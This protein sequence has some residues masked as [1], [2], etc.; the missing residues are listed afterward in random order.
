MSTVENSPKPVISAVHGM[1]L[2]G[3]MELALASHWRL[4]T[5]DTV[6]GLP[7]VHLGILPGAGGTQVF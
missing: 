1:A 4:T 5:S 7:E 3:G 6:L 2:G